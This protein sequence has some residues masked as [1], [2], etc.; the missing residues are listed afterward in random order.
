MFCLSL[1]VLNGLGDGQINRVVTPIWSFQIQVVKRD[2]FF[3][4]RSVSV[5]KPRAVSFAVQ[6]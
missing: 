3:S 6:R 1:P 4:H 5:D 2:R